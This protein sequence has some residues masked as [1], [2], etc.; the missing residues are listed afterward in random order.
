MAKQLKSQLDAG[1]ARFGIEPIRQIISDVLGPASLTPTQYLRRD[2]V[3]RNVAENRRAIASSGIEKYFSS[4]K[5]EPVS[6]WI[7][8]G[9][10]QYI[11]VI[12]KKGLKAQHGIGKKARSVI[13]DY[14]AKYLPA[15]V[16]KPV[17]FFPYRKYDHVGK[18]QS[19]VRTAV[20]QSTDL[21][22]YNPA[23]A[24]AQAADAG[25]FGPQISD[26]QLVENRRIQSKRESAEEH[27]RK[28]NRERYRRL[29]ASRRKAQREQLYQQAPWM[30]SLVASGII[31]RKY[32]P[33]IA[34][35]IDKI[36]NSGSILS[37][38][39]KNPGG[40]LA[41]LVAAAMSAIGR[42]L[43]NYV[44]SNAKLAVI[45]HRYRSFG[46]PSGALERAMIFA[47]MDM[48]ARQEAFHRL[49]GRWGPAVEIVLRA[50][51]KATAGKEGWQ[52]QLVAQGYELSADDLTV[53]DILTKSRELMESDF[54]LE[55][56][57][58]ASDAKVEMKAGKHGVL[59]VG[60]AF[61]DDVTLDIPQNIGIISEAD[62]SYKRYKAKQDAARK[63]ALSA[64]LY[65]ASGGGSNSTTNNVGDTSVSVQN[66]I[67]VNSG[68]DVKDVVTSAT[69][70]ALEAARRQ[71]ILNQVSGMYKA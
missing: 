41:G 48:A 34:N 10:G 61:L 66:N 21:A 56:K 62:N 60:A 15:V 17:D 68:S 29:Q 5:G 33:A 28:S 69:N 7:P 24:S 51:S 19:F 35:K 45:S 8:I 13:Q 53:A 46:K 12:N 14:D 47:G 40:S 37:N 32:I 67:T 44:D 18:R 23:F 43:S 31:D 55:K 58:R 9:N 22:I 42:V 39:I 57:T 16:Q 64:D 70:G 59:G 49:Q 52:R 6:S 20:G 36:I 11:E 2:R 30:K 38:A 4:A 71:K 3:L 65:D 27:E 1:L 26:E 50:L 54:V 63:A 25:L